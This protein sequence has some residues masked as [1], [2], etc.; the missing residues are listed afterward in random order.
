MVQTLRAAKFSPQMA[1]V[2]DSAF[3]HLRDLLRFKPVDYEELDYNR[4]KAFEL[5]YSD[6]Q[7]YKQYMAAVEGKVF[8]EYPKIKLASSCKRTIAALGASRREENLM[9]PFLR[10]LLIGVSAP[11]NLMSKG[12]PKEIPVFEMQRPRLMQSRS[13][14][15]IA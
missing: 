11:P 6:M 14:R 9:S 8:G 5:A 15:R 4:E 13:R 12:Q 1:V 10:A 7:K 2:E 3:D